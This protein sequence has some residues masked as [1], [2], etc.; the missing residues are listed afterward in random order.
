MPPQSVRPRR[1][2]LGMGQA[3]SQNFMTG[4]AQVM[5]YKR[6]LMQKIL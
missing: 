3:T 1:D 5:K 6:K 2:R 4:Q